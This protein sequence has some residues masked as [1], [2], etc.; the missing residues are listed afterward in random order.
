MRYVL[1]G[2]GF[3]VAVAVL[4]TARTSAQQKL[5][6]EVAAAKVTIAVQNEPT[7][8]ISA[9]TGTE[10][11][12]AFAPPCTKA[13]CMPILFVMVGPVGAEENPMATGQG[14]IFY[15]FDYDGYL[16]MMTVDM[17]KQPINDELQQE[18]AD[19]LAILAAHLPTSQ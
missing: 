12:Y 15:D 2:L 8:E 10:R 13:T 7:S 14:E 11:L 19:T 6:I 5:P 4:T 3:L 18:Y 1:Y 17:V 9:N 16:D